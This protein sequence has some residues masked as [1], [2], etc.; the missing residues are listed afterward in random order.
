MY[1]SQPQQQQQQQLCGGMSHLI[2][3]HPRST[4]LATRLHVTRC[5]V[6]LCQSLAATRGD[7]Q[8]RRRRRRRRGAFCIELTL[9]LK[10]AAAA[11]ANRRRRTAP[12]KTHRNMQKVNERV[13][14]VFGL[15]CVCVFWCCRQRRVS[16]THSTDR[17]TDTLE[18]LELKHRA[19]SVLKREKNKNK[20]YTKVYISQYNLSAAVCTTRPLATCL[21]VLVF[22]FYGVLLRCEA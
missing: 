11:A 6:I 21:P 22:G 8:R 7:R 18:A 3:T 9:N 12:H 16:C 10:A 17:Q 14:R 5:V 20:M 13:S 15:L 2:K 19:W 1:H 4:R